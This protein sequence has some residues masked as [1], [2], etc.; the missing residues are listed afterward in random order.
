MNAPSIS[1]SEWLVAS[2]IWSE[3]GLTA[4]EVAARLADRTA[5][6]QKTVNTFLARLVTKGVLFT[7]P[8]GRAFRYFP[9]IPREH[10]VRRESE[11]FLQRVFGGA[12]APMLAHF[13]ET[14]DLSD[15]EV[16]RLRKILK[17][18]G[19]TRDEK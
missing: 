4:S 12:V 6:K 8:E 13:C 11:S 7:R 10:C 2:V 5:W 14:N 17:R 3:E 15:E 19:K 18:K 16:A 1:E 9:K